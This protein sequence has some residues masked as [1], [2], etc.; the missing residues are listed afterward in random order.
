MFSAQSYAATQNPDQILD[1]EFGLDALNGASPA[2]QTLNHLSA[3]YR[4]FW[5][6]RCQS[7][8]CCE[9][10]MH[11]DL[12]YLNLLSRKSDFLGPRLNGRVAKIEEL[13]ALICC[14]TVSFGLI[15]SHVGQLASIT[16]NCNG[17]V[18]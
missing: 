15:L 18:M 9:K 11:E 13:Q 6:I 1:L 7:V 8:R 4:S 10:V 17:L 16:L 3:K 5:R 12:I 14:W 2:L